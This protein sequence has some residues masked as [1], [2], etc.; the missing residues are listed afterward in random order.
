MVLLRDEVRLCSGS[1]KAAEAHLS[2]TESL[3]GKWSLMVESESSTVDSAA[4]IIVTAAPLGLFSTCAVLLLRLS[5]LFFCFISC[6][7]CFMQWMCS[8]NVV[9]KLWF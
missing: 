1:L 4:V 6:I 3:M 8:R 2:V 5:I 7:L 9:N